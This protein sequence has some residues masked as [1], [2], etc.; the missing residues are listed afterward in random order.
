MIYLYAIADRP[1]LPLPASAGMENGCLFT[2]AHQEIAAVVSPVAA[3]RVTPTKANLWRHEMV[4]E[5][6]MAD[7]TVLP[8]RFGTVLAD[9]NAVLGTLAAHGRRFAAALDRVRGRVELGLRVLW[10]H[11]E[12]A[13]SR[14]KAGTAHEA[15]GGRAYLLAKLEEDRQRRALRH[16]AE[17]WAARIHAPLS[18]LAVDHV[19]SVLITSRLLL[20][21][22]YLVKLDQ[23]EA[24]RQQVE[25][26]GVAYPNLRFL[27]TG[28]WPAYSFVTTTVDRAIVPEEEELDA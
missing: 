13:P 19:R 20:T 3:G 2:V 1:G 4:V 21:A 14:G 9:E 27:C 15:G 5:R 17:D 12:R 25:G 24:F 28:P 7:R 18:R 6:L 23:M 26:L 22:S 11:G 8:V 16:E 10:D